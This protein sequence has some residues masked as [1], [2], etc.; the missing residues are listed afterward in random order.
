MGGWSKAVL[1]ASLSMTGVPLR[2]GGGG[3]GEAARAGP[4]LVDTC[5][6]LAG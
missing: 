5:L 3:G 6:G 4:A 2:F 1:D